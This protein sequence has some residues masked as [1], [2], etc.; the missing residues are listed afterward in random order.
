M[1]GC[2]AEYIRQRRW[3]KQ[4]VRINSHLRARQNSALILIPM[5]SPAPTFT[6]APPPRGR[7]KIRAASPIDRLEGSIVTEVVVNQFRRTLV[8]AE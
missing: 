7:G 4:P 1:T 8:G 3:K 5:L 6:P 2:R